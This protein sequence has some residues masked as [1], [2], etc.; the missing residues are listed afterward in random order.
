MTREA[1]SGYAT[2]VVNAVV[3]GDTT[4]PAADGLRDAWGP[5]TA[6]NGISPKT[7]ETCEL[8]FSRLGQA[9]LDWGD[10]TNVLKDVRK[11]TTHGDWAHW[12]QRWSEHGADYERRFASGI[13]AGHL[14]TPRVSGLKAAACPHLGE[15][16]LFDG[17]ASQKRSRPQVDEQVRP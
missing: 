6:A 16:F 7:F 10:I 17:P 11:E 15:F 8:F 12:H 4:G 14:E 9:G 3:Q 5:R 13:P 2:A 1:V